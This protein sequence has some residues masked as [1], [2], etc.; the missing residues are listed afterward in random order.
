MLFRSASQTS[1]IVAEA[2]VA[3]GVDGRICA[4]GVL[5]YSVDTT[6]TTSAG[7]I[8]VLDATPGSNGCGENGEL[9][10][11][12]DATLSMKGKKSFEVSEWGVKVTLVEETKNGQFKIEVEYS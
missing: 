9:E 11:L 7:S 10:P 6:V 5:L 1:A 2:R 3:K 8:K 4:P 12:N